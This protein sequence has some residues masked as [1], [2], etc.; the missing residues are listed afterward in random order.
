MKFVME[1][2]M[3]LIAA[4]EFEM[5]KAVLMRNGGALSLKDYIKTMYP[6]TWKEKLDNITKENKVLGLVQKIQEVA[7]ELLDHV[8]QQ[9]DQ[10]IELQKQTEEQAA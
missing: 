4:Q 8:M 7:P 1:V 9:M 6:N 5:N 10:F 2:E 3:N